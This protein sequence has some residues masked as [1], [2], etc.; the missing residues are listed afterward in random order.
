MR[1]TYKNIRNIAAKLFDIFAEYFVSDLEISNRAIET[2][3]AYVFIE[4][5][6]IITFIII[7]R[8]RFDKS[9]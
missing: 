2:I 9:D 3:F 5:F 4:T 8:Y 6:V 1:K 7:T